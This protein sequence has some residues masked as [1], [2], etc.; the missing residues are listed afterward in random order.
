IALSLAS[1]FN[2]L[3][4]ETSSWAVT[5]TDGH[6]SLTLAAWW[7]LIV[8]SPIFWFLLLRGL[9]RHLVWSRLL[10]ALAKLELR[11]V[12]THPDGKAGLGFIGR[13]PNAYALFIFGISCVLGAA[14]AHQLL[15]KELTVTAYGCV[16]AAWLL[17]VLALFA[18]PLAAFSK[19]LADL[20]ER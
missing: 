2:L 15:Q 11:L 19:P 9:W 10:R 4:A 17:I 13:Y 8:S 6:K 20:K 5:V 12:A 14:L 7:C 18:Y 1:L 3:G 16:M